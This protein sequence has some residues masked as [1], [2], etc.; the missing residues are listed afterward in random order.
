M[1]DHINSYKR[2]SL[3]DKSPYEMLAFMYGE[4]LLS[5]LGANLVAPNLVTPGSSIFRKEGDANA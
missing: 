4:R 5:L 2:P 1:T 3:G